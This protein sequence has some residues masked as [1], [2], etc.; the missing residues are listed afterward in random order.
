MTSALDLLADIATR[1]VVEGAGIR[2]TPAEWERAIGSDFVDD[3][4]KKRFRRD[5]GLVE[6]GFWRVGGEWR[7]GL[8]ALQVHR[9][10]SGAETIGPASLR[11]RYGEFPPS[12]AFADLRPRL[13]ELRYIPDSDT[14]RYER[15]YLPGSKVAIMVSVSNVDG[16]P[17]AGSVWALHLTDEPD[18]P[19]RPR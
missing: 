10:W 11:T 9:L 7:C 12:V 17:P 1:G 18:I 4:V 16:G 5:Y 3:R 15:Y 13:P 8:F 19:L 2:A 6:L 14:T